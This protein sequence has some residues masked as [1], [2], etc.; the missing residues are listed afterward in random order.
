VLDVGYWHVSQL[1]KLSILGC[2]EPPGKSHLPGGYHVSLLS[3]NF[4]SNNLVLLLF[5]TRLFQN[6][7]KKALGALRV[8]HF[9]NFYADTNHAYC[10]HQK[11]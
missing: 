10:I 4:I 1:L 6:G 3:T 2:M 9:L 5:S 7:R 11:I 8:G